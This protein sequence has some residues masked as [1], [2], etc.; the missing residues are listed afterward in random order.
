MTHRKWVW[1]TLRNTRQRKASTETQ[2]RNIHHKQFRVWASTNSP[3]ALHIMTIT[4]LSLKHSKVFSSSNGFC[5]QFPNSLS[6]FPFSNSM[7]RASPQGWGDEQG[8]LKDQTIL[9]FWVI[10]PNACPIHLSCSVFLAV[11][12]S[13]NHGIQTSYVQLCKGENR[14]EYVA[15]KVQAHHFHQITKRA[16]TDG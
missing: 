11:D 14:K 13:L 4:G 2:V 1:L 12:A 10:L 6:P 7:W 8:S 15:R 16:V 5:A 3:C 9:G